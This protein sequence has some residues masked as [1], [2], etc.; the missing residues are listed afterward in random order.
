MASNPAYIH[1]QIPDPTVITP[2]Q[3]FHIFAPK[4]PHPDFSNDVIQHT[5]RLKAYDPLDLSQALCFAIE[6]RLSNQQTI[7]D[8]LDLAERQLLGTVMDRS[9]SNLR[10]TDGER[11]DSL[12]EMQAIKNLALEF[13]PTFNKMLFGGSLTE[14]LKDVQAY[15]F[16]ALKASNPTHEA[17][18]ENAIGWYQEEERTI[19]IRTNPPMYDFAGTAA[20]EVQKYLTIF[21][22]ELVHTFFWAWGCKCA[23]RCSQDE[24]LGNIFGQSGHGPAWMQVMH[25]ISQALEKDLGWKIDTGMAYSCEIEEKNSGFKFPESMLNSW[26][27]RRINFSQEDWKLIPKIWYNVHPCVTENPPCRKIQLVH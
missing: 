6:S 24:V 15:N 10:L 18:T 7:L 11:S 21:V 4:N 12:L 26:N 20:T 19:Y 5:L 25:T 23:N 13:F 8:H 2:P 22:H 3:D 1:P 27:M 17:V 16:D 9:Y 14:Y